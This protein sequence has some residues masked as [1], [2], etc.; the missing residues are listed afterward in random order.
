MSAA[1]YFWQNNALVLRVRVQPRASRDA[2][3]GLHADRL[4]IRLAAAPVDGKANDRLTEMLARL[5][6]VA[7]SDVTILSGAGCR[8]K[9][10]RIRQP[11]ILPPGVE[12][13]GH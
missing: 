11:R 4:K 6:D 10:V 12:P 2:V 9:R 13:D 7:K 1:W 5:C 8:D 3:A